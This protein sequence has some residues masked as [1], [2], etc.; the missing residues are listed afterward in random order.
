MKRTSGQDGGVGKLHITTE[1]IKTRL[2]NKFHPDSLENQAV[3]KSDNQGLKEATYI[4]IGRRGGDAE[5]WWN[6]WSHIHVW[7]VKIGKDT[8]EA[9]DPSP[10]PD[11]SAQGS[12]TG[13]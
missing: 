2:Q 4:Q 6:G 12:S 8:S 11:Y 9:S 13:M 10:R 7:W 5:R 3:W 1:K